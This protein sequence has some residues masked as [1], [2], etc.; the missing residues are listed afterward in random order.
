[1]STRKLLAGALVSLLFWLAAYTV[2]T[3]LLSWWYHAGFLSN[4]EV[5]FGPSRL[6][7][8]AR[9]WLALSFFVGPICL[10][11]LAIFLAE[12]RWQAPVHR[13]FVR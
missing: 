5:A 9:F 11:W 13:R 6:A 4:P 3:G 10:W 2:L 12:W 8:M 7:W 1:V